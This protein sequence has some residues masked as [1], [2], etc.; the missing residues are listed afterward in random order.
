MLV[1]AGLFASLRRAQRR[2]LR[3]TKRKKIRCIDYC[4]ILGRGPEKIYMVGKSASPQ[5]DA[6]VAWFL[7]HVEYD[8]EHGE[9]DRYH[10]D[11]LMLINGGEYYYEHDRDSEP[12]TELKARMSKYDGCTRPVLWDA[13]DETR[14]KEMMRLSDNSMFLFALYSE[15]MTPHEKVWRFKDGRRAGL[16]R[17]RSPGRPVGVA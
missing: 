4:A 14:L 5:H 6:E 8:E 17:G 11:A 16:P 12:V 15:A 2:L 3:L 10:C 9:D 1:H 13:P 7:M